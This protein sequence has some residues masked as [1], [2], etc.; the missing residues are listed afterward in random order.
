MTDIQPTF[1]KA[2]VDQLVEFY[3]CICN[4]AEFRFTA[5]EAVK[6]AK[7]MVFMKSHMDK[8]NDSIMELIRV[9]KAHAPP[10]T[11]KAKK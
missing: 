5:P 10:K 4:K 7:L 9:T 3:N 1:S 11:V 2:E 8:V 6:F